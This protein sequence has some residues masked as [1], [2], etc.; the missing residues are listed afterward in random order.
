MSL[1][2]LRCGEIRNKADDFVENGVEAVVLA[3]DGKFEPQIFPGGEGG[4]TV[5]RAQLADA[6]D[7]VVADQGAVRL[8]GGHGREG[9]VVAVVVFDRPVGEAGVGQHKSAEQRLFGV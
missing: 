2:K 3:A 7:A 8:A 4:E 6:V 9:L 5:F 1:L